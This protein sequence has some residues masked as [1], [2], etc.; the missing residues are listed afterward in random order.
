MQMIQLGYKLARLTKVKEYRE[1]AGQ[2]WAWVRKVGILD[3]VT[4]QVITMLHQMLY[5][6]PHP[7]FR[8]M[9]GYH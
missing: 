6:P 9:T 1:R 5:R 4:A 3:N 8:C 7:L 2:V